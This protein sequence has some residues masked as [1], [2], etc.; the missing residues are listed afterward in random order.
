MI[1]A[2]FD[3]IALEVARK[4]TADDEGQRRAQLQCAIV[5]AMSDAMALG[6]RDR[7]FAQDEAWTQGRKRGFEAG[8]DAAM[9]GMRRPE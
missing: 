7:L 6:A 2:W 4:F 5:K 8:Y 9:A 3:T 1:P